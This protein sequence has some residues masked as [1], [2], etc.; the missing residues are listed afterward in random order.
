MDQPKDRIGDIQ[1]YKYLGIPAANGSNDGNK[2]GSHCQK[3]PGGSGRCLETSSVAGLGHRH[4]F[5]TSH[6]KPSRD[7]KPAP[8]RERC[9]Q[10]ASPSGCEQQSRD[11]V[12]QTNQMVADKEQDRTPVV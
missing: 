7:L 3:P 5:P 11:P 4:I 10:E 8:G 1:D 12:G 6:Q 9:H 2:E